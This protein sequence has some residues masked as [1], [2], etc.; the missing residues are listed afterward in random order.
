MKERTGDV[1]T[2]S[3]LLILLLFLAYH[4]RAHIYSTPLSSDGAMNVQVPL[5]LL[6]H[7]R[8]ATN[9][10]GYIDF[11]NVVQS[12]SPLL[13]PIAL[14][15]RLGGVSSFTAQI[16]NAVYLILSLLVTFIFVKN[17]TNKWVGLLTVVI[18]IY[19]PY[20]FRFGLRGYGEIPALFY[21]MAGLCL[22]NALETNKNHNPAFLAVL[23]GVAWGLACLTKTVILIFL[24]SLFAAIL[25]DVF[26]TKK[27]SRKMYILIALGGLLTISLFE[28]WKLTVLGL[29]DYMYWWNE[30]LY[31]IAPQTGVVK[32]LADTPSLFEKIEIHLIILSVNFGIPF[33]GSI[34]LIFV[35]CVMFIHYFIS[36]MRKWRQKISLSYLILFGTSI[37]YVLWWIVLTPTSKAWNRRIINGIILLDISNMILLGLTLIYL[38]PLVKTVRN[39][40]RHL[41]FSNISLILLSSL[42]VMLII[43][44]SAQLYNNRQNIPLKADDSPSPDKIA[45]DDIAKKIAQLPSNATIYGVNW[46]QCPVLSFLSGRR[47][48]NIENIY[49]Y[50]KFNNEENYFVDERIDHIKDPKKIDDVL[51]RADYKLIDANNYCRLYK[52][53]HLY[54]YQDFSEEEKKGAVQSFIDLTKADYPYIRGLTSNGYEKEY[55]WVSSNSAVL[56]KYEKQNLFYICIKIL[57]YELF[58]SDNV[59]LSISLDDKLRYFYKISK[60]GLFEE[61]FK[62]PIGYKNGQNVTVELHLSD[63]LHRK[64]RA[65]ERGLAFVLIKMGFTDDSLI[66]DDN[67]L[68]RVKE[69]KKTATTGTDLRNPTNEIISRQ[70]DS[71]RDTRLAHKERR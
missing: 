10:D 48:Y 29:K 41:N 67:R 60:N 63:V 24:P 32:G 35:P 31:A 5:N 16:P 44:L 42:S 49:N 6:Q 30:E 11:D 50:D 38:L 56:L 65:D 13:L 17:V 69:F 22:F 34:Y 57:N 28:I 59:I 66:N 23:T 37:S 39:N 18:I 2:Y 8:Y 71:Q 21:F 64:Q 20:L 68:E 70:M 47:F 54:P 53:D 51:S 61:S 4:V 19:I 3:L 9:Y 36:T 25:V 52:I 1:I 62:V 46:L 26:I 33:I 43:T 58:K 15:F 7:G 14:A 55:H 45:S 27:L 12:G 40:K